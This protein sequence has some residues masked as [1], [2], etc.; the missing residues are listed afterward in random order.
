[1]KPLRGIDIVLHLDRFDGIAEHLL[2]D[3][4]IESQT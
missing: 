1:M 2:L 4:A 3:L